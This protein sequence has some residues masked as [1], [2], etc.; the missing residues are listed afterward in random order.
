MEQ[1]HRWKTVDCVLG[2]RRCRPQVEQ[3]ARRRVARQVAAGHEPW[4]PTRDAPGFQVRVQADQIVDPGDAHPTLQLADRPTALGRAQGG[5]GRRPPGGVPRHRALLRLR[6]GPLHEHQ[7]LQVGAGALPDHR[8]AVPVAAVD[9]DVL[10]HPV[11]GPLQVRDHLGHRRAREVAV[12]HRDDDAPRAGQPR[13]DVGVPSPVA[14]D[15]RAAHHDDHHRRLLVGVA[16]FEG[17]W[18]VHVEIVPGV[19][20]IADASAQHRVCDVGVGYLEEPRG[21][22]H[23]IPHQPQGKHEQGDQ[24]AEDAA[25]GAELC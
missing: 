14:D 10:E 18:Q 24:A 20:A 17:R 13:A 15:P 9:A 22:K 25:S 2:E 23:R 16:V 21:E 7:G 19:R 5:A 4:E 1:D 6:D 3:A 8:D 12:V 11:H